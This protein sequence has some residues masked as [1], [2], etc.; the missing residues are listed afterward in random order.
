MKFRENELKHGRV[1]MIAVLGVV[2]GESG[3]N[4]FGPDIDITGPAIYQYQQAETLFQAFS[5]NVI[6]FIL[7]I[8]GYNIVNGW[9]E[10]GEAEGI[11]GLKPGY[12]SGDLKFDPLSL[13]NLYS[14][15]AAF[16]EIQTKEVR[17]RVRVRLRVRFRVRFRV[18]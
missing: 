16:K 17:V 3:A 8:E 15:P 18:K 10:Q 14:A 2:I 9:E 12:I 7:A 13:K 4:F 1:A 5:A 11:A 6:G